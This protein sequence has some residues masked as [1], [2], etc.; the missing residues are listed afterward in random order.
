MSAYEKLLP[1][2]LD[3]SKPFWDACRRHE[4]TIQ[5]CLECGHRRWPIGPACTHCLSTDFSWVG[6]AGTGEVWS[7]I[8]YHQAFNSAWAA[9][10]PYN[11]ALIRMDEGHT[12]ISNI[13]GV[14]PDEIR[15][16]QRVE[17]L[18]EDVTDEASVPKFR[19]VKP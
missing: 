7:W 12:M 18:F 9:D 5:E 15:I 13:V 14:T 6:V 17:V 10:V 3:G 8:T 4:L 11:V 2:T 19:P 16:G 1:D